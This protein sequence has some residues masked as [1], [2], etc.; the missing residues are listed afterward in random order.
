[1]TYNS[2]YKAVII[3]IIESITVCHKFGGGV[4]LINNKMET[5]SVK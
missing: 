1:M 4:N 5:R 2:T 3:E